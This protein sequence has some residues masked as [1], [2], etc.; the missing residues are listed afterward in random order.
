[1][2]AIHLA[3]VRG[4][5]CGA[6]RWIEKVH[7]LVFINYLIEKC[8]V[9]HWKKNYCCVFDCLP[10]HISLLEYTIVVSSLKGMF[11]DF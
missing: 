1:M 10:T 4:E 7:V 11:M 3:G 2:A 6:V 5:P 9:K 8:A